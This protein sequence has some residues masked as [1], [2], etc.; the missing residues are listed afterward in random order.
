MGWLFGNNQFGVDLTELSGIGV[1]M[2]QLTVDG[3]IGVPDQQFKG[4]YEVGSYL[5]ALTNLLAGPVRA[6]G[7]D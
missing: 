5:L 4:S 1:P 6:D 2:R 3:R 7:R